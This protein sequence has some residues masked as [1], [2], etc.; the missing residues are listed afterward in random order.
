MI[1]DLYL[2]A[3]Y[4]EKDGSQLVKKNQT[5]ISMKKALSF[6]LGQFYIMVFNRH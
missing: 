2:S 1:S 5:V 3:D 6:F 4:K